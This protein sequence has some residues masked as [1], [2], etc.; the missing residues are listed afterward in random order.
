MGTVAECRT[1]G[2][3]LKPAPTARSSSLWLAALGIK[4]R[5]GITR[6]YAAPESLRSTRGILWIAPAS[7]MKCEIRVPLESI[8]SQQLSHFALQYVLTAFFL[9]RGMCP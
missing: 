3:T 6:D 8:L 2:R 5:T 4:Y 7:R 1:A 9:C